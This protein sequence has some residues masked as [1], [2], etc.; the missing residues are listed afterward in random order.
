MFH[1][2]FMAKDQRSNSVFPL[3]P[4]FTPPRYFCLEEGVN[5]SEVS[6]C[7][8]KSLSGGIL[9]AAFLT[10]VHLHFKAFQSAWVLPVYQHGG[11]R[12]LPRCG[13]DL[14]LW[15][16]ESLEGGQGGAE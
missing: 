4:A 7:P 3:T 5:H 11:A 14:L 2:T 6:V 15:S 9:K 8:E 16:D 10:P 12:L 1:S 13:A